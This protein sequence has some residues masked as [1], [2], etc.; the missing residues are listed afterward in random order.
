M[1]YNDE[2]AGGLLELIPGT[3]RQ[4]QCP[5]RATSAWCPSQSD[6]PGRANRVQAM[7]VGMLMPM[8]IPNHQ[9]AAVALVSA[10]LKPN[11]PTASNAPPMSM[12][13]TRPGGPRRGLQS[14]AS[15]WRRRR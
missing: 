12:S 3:R 13:G 5:L 10:T 7:M 9:K 1:A 8:D 14:S 2:I 4:R 6:L 15:R 11:I